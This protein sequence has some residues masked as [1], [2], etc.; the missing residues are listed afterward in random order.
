MLKMNSVYMGLSLLVVVFNGSA[1]ELYRWVDQDGNVQFTQ[2]PPPETAQDVTTRPLESARPTPPAASPANAQN[3][4]PSDSAVNASELPDE[5]LSDEAKKIQQHKA[6]NCQTARDN[7]AR[8]NA[9]EPLMEADP[10]NPS[11]YRLMPD[12]TRRRET[13]RAQAYLDSFCRD[14]DAPQ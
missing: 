10:A 3:D 14:P 9:G 12:D 7:L 13:E 11:L 1:A 5:E 8:L 2:T 6:E 4:Q